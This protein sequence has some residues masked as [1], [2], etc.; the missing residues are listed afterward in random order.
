MLSYPLLLSHSTPTSLADLLSHENADIAIAVIEVLE[1]WLDEEVLEVDEDEVEDTEAEED[2]RRAAMKALVKGLVE[3]GVVEMAVAGLSRF[4]E[5]DESERGGVYHTLGKPCSTVVCHVEYRLTCNFFL[6]G[7]VENLL[8][9]LPSLA[10]PLLLSSSPL[11]GFLLAR[12][13]KDKQASE[14]DQ[15]RWYAAELLAFILGLPVDGV[16]VA[17]QRLINEG[18]V[19][20]LL[21]VLSVS[22]SSRLSPLLNPALIPER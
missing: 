13:S 20:A 16:D 12:F 15:N 7:L 21:K 14:L 18:A 4:N 17:K 3:A 6:P 2:G 22:S 10:T 1:E 9:L 11:L 8:S 19:D 5:E